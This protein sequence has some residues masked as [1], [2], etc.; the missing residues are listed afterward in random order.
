MLFCPCFQVYSRSG[1]PAFLCYVFQWS[2]PCSPA[3]SNRSL[4]P[5]PKGSSPRCRALAAQPFA[6]HSCG[7]AL[8]ARLLMP[9]PFG[10]TLATHPLRPAPCDPPLAACPLRPYPCGPPLASRPLRPAPCSPPIAAWP[11]HCTS[12]LGRGCVSMQSTVCSNLDLVVRIR[13][14]PMVVLTEKIAYQFYY[15][16]FYILYTY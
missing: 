8:V 14:Q 9:A 16:N 6:A 12:A 10:P 15:I 11:C 5:G 13:H 3:I 1:L 4:R 7:H 2:G